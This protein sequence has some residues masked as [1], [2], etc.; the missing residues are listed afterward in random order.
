MDQLGVP[1]K[2][3]QQRLG[4]SDASLTLDVYIHVASGDDARSAEQL[5]GVLQ[6]IAPKSETGSKVASAKCMYLN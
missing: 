2:V 5:D 3:R 4:H 1:L 6:S